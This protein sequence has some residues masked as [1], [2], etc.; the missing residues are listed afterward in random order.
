MELKDD[1]YDFI[2]KYLRINGRHI[3]SGTG[4]DSLGPGRLFILAVAVAPKDCVAPLT[5]KILYNTLCLYI[6]IY[7]N[8]NQLHKSRRSSLTERQEKQT[9]EC[10]RLAAGSYITSSFSPTLKAHRFLSEI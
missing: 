2:L 3:L 1:F 9:T 6:C 4:S 8:N 10:W 5:E 7:K